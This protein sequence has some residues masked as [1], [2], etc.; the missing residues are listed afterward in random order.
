[1]I[2]R[3]R[4]SREGGGPAGLHWK[5][6]KKMLASFALATVLLTSSAFAQRIPRQA[7]EWKA[8]TLDN[9]ILDLK[10]FKGKYV[11]VTFLLST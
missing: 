8:Q 10:Q 2:R 3:G 1:V 9:K 4:P 6:M 5:T 7:G 11:L